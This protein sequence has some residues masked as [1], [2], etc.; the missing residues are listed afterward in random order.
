MGCYVNQ[1]RHMSANRY[2]EFISI[3]QFMLSF[4]YKINPEAEEN[5]MIDVL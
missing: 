5:G 1:I 3:K 4:V 2:F